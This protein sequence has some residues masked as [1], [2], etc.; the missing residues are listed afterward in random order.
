MKERML[1]FV[2]IGFIGLCIFIFFY[3]RNLPIPIPKKASTE[4]AKI[5]EPSITFLDPWRGAK[6]AKVTIVEYADFECIPCKQLNPIIDIALNTFPDQVRL[7]WKDMP[8]ESVH[9]NA[10]KASIAAQCAARQGKFWEYHDQLF[11]RQSFLTPAEYPRIANELG[12][13][14]S[15]FSKCLENDDTA[16]LVKK[17]TQ[18]G[19][20]LGV[21]ATPALYID[22]ELLIGTQTPE[23]LIR[24]IQ[25]ALD[26]Q[27]A[28][29]K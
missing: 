23:D 2:T 16:P 5:Q 25:T 6:D 10:T 28:P 19:I 3:Y 14:E 18:E 1:A 26:K 22:H 7:V 29:T 13:N 17:N 4:T 27:K 9:T 24:A 15:L 20:G 12:L 21:V 8:N 11:N